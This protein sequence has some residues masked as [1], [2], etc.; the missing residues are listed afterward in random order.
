MGTRSKMRWP[1]PARAAE[2]V[3]HIDRHAGAQ[4]LLNRLADADHRVRRVKML[5][6]QSGVAHVAAGAPMYNLHTLGHA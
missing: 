1:K 4:T 3:L 6:Q 2:M 5:R